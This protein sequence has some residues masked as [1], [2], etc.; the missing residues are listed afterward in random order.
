MDHQVSIVEF[1]LLPE[2]RPQSPCRRRR[3]PR[4]WG[5][6][7]GGRSRGRGSGARGTK[8]QP[9]LCLKRCRA[10]GNHSWMTKVQGCQMARAAEICY[11]TIRGENCQQMR[12]FGNPVFP[13][14][15]EGREVARRAE[16]RHADALRLLEMCIGVVK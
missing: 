8:R 7:A 6:R 5:R 11:S 9:L 14:G 12:L 4:V 13:F 10:T 2:W 15:E 3:S 16:R 1:P